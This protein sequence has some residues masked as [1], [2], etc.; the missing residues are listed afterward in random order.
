MSS[1]LMK[2]DR[3]KHISWHIFSY[4]Q[5]LIEKEKL[6]IRKVK[7]EHNIVDMLTK[8]LPTYKHTKLIYARV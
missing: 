7:S 2:V 5:D 8:A 6:E 4:T 3:T 1:D